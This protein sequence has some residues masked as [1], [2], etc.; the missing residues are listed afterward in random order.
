MT[1][2]K[3]SCELAER[4]REYGATPSF[5][6]HGGF[7][8]SVLYVCGRGARSQCPRGRAVK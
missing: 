3:T 2:R 4:M 5:L 6:G 7:P 8:G 1:I